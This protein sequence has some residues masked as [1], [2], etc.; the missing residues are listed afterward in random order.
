MSSVFYN[1]P[2]LL[3]TLAT[4]LSSEASALSA[5][6]KSLSLPSFSIT[7]IASSLA[8][9]IIVLLSQYANPITTPVRVVNI[10]TAYLQ[11]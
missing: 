9:R 5:L 1:S 8:F 6:I 3:N 11:K 7:P 4:F 2:K 10:A